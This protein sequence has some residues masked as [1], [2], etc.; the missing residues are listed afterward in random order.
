MVGTTLAHYRVIS[1][2]GRGGM[3]EVF[4]AEDL[5]LGR[6][7]ALKVLPPNLA[8]DA[9]RQRRFD[10]EA[11]AIAALNHPNIVTIYGIERFSEATVLAME[12]VDGQPLAHLIPEG[13]MRLP[14][15]LRLAIPLAEAIGFAH[16]Q[17]IVH[18]DLKPGNV[19]VTRDGRVKVLDF[20]LAKLLDRPSGF[21]PADETALVADGT[22][23]APGTQL[24]AIVGTVHYMAPEQAQ[25]LPVDHRA[26]IFSLGILLYEMA[27]GVRPFGGDTAMAVLSSIIKEPPRALAEVKPDLPLA[28][29][30]VVERC[31]EKDR[32]RR[33]QDAS[34]L[35]AAL[36]VVADTLSPHGGARSDARAPVSPGAEPALAPAE[37][38]AR[39]RR[40]RLLAGAAGLALVLAAAAAGAWWL[41]GRERTPAVPIVPDRV[42][43]A[44]IVNRTGDASLDSVG[45]M[46]SGSIA[47]L[48]AL[49]GIDVVASRDV[50]D[51]RRLGAARVVSGDITVVGSDLT[52]RG[53]IADAQAL[54]ELRQFDP[55]V[56]TRTAASELPSRIEQQVVGATLM[57]MRG[58][59][60]MTGFSPQQLAIMVLPSYDAYKEF[61]TGL[62]H[63]GTN[64]PE[65]AAH[66][67]RVLELDPRLWWCLGWLVPAYEALGQ[68]DKAEAILEKIR[69]SVP[70]SG[71]A[72]LQYFSARLAGRLID[73]HTAATS[74]GF[75]Q[76]LPSA[77]IVAW[78]ARDI[79]RPQDA[80]EAL[81]PFA[82]P[83][84]RMNAAAWRGWV[85]TI[86]QAHHMLGQY[87][88]ER[89]VGARALA[90][91]PG[92]PLGYLAEARALAAQGRADDLFKVLDAC[93]TVPP[94]AR[95]RP[96]TVFVTVAAELRAHGHA[97]DAT[98]VAEQALRWL[99]GL[100]TTMARS[101]PTQMLRGEALT[102]LERW[103]DA[104]AVFAKV[105]A[106]AKSSIDAR[107][108]IG[109]IAARRGDVKA[110][111]TM[112]DELARFN[113]PYVRGAHTLGRARI[114][115]AL[116]E[117][118]RT[119]DLLREA[120]AE[121][122]PLA[123]PL[124]ADY[125]FEALR[126]YA[127][128]D[129]LTAM[130]RGTK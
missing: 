121:G 49:E 87:D 33:L 38:A 36:E 93:L 64:M 25:G 46:A 2:L 110:A 72:M 68:F 35:R 48:L 92:T 23:T 41:F 90:A 4:L 88:Q 101:V 123:W 24:G 89:E 22:V 32:E 8:G 118:E 58:A 122:Q 51:G 9:E 26:D 79:G 59:G 39:P 55:I 31:L 19:M 1:L 10:Q 128:F 77:T 84:P 108:E 86:A 21:T 113:R 117:R 66:F 80:L 73:A 28:F 125:A 116:G 102:L 27:A 115:A 94:T 70:P 12:F 18:R 127:P 107:S 14:A 17:G 105:A 6:K 111:R 85:D 112:I 71:K 11:R 67:G 30:G 44:P 63:F 75:G 91:V 61:A 56:V 97:E 16:R 7:V 15:L 13:G 45:S 104:S 81:R 126:G 100:D 47:R 52:F 57:M 129:E 20:G 106:S 114:V 109:V 37:A 82:P 34:E 50:P 54:G 29:T 95:P 83:D 124:H 69:P 65:A 42:A 5:A 60:G 40:R 130:N 99:D 62:E 3:G 43:L 53:R 98:R 76:H 103:S 74:L 120:F 78:T 96:G 119:I